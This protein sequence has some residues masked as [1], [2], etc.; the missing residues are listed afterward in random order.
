[1]LAARKDQWADGPAL[2]RHSLAVV[3]VPEMLDRTAIDVVPMLR[4]PMP[5]LDAR[6]RRLR[7]RRPT[8][9]RRLISQKTAIRRTSSRVRVGFVEADP[10][11]RAAKP[12]STNPTR[13]Q[14]EASRLLQSR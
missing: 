12:Q 9:S 10:F 3:R 5:P 14:G 7:T 8:T 4:L 1:M 6:F 2:C 11:R 13:Q